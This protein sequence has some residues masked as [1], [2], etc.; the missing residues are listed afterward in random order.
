M[1]GNNSLTRKEFEA[2]WYFV[3][4]WNKSLGSNTHNT[5]GKL[6]MS[7]AIDRTITV[8]IIKIK[9]LLPQNLA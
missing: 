7:G 4:L 6:R 1:S 8:T 5:M 2:L 9:H 3:F